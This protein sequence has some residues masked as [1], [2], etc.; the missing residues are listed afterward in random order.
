MGPD[1]F[2]ITDTIKV[3]MEIRFHNVSKHTSDSLFTV[4]GTVR[5]SSTNEALAGAFVL[6][7]LRWVNGRELG[8]TT[9]Y[10][11]RFK[12]NGVGIGDTLWFKDIGYA[13]KTVFV[14]DV[15]NRGRRTW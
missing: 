9:D 5:D 13:S 12:L 6:D 2:V 3:P 11:S 15:V 10:L 7:R 1:V 4:E 14:G 8:T